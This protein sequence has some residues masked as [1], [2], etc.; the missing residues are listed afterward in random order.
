M[1]PAMPEST[2]SNIGLIFFAE[3]RSARAKI[4]QLQPSINERPSSLCGKIRSRAADI[5]IPTTTGRIETTT[6]C[7]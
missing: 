3:P 4:S 5:I 1:M 6:L 2:I 7:T